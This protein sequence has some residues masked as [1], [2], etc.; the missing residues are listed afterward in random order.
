MS[1]ARKV[2]EKVLDA[3]ARK[4]YKFHASQCGFRGFRS[5]ETA[6]LRVT[7][8][9]TN[10]CRYLAVLDL[11]QA[12]A[13]VPRGD[14]IEQIRTKL[15]ANTANM[16][17]AML[18]RTLVST[19]GDSDGIVREMER[20][21]P[22]GSPLSP[23]LFNFFI[24]PLAGR[25]EAWVDGDFEN[26]VNL[27]ADDIIL[28][29]PTASKMQG[30]LSICEDFASR[31]GLEWGVTKCHA[32]RA[33]EAPATPLYL[34]GNELK[35]CASAEYLGVEVDASGV[36]DAATLERICRAGARIQM[37]KASVIARPRLT[38]A[39]LQQVYGALIRPV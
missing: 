25:I 26:A 12:Y 22:E 10:G 28:L 21:V 9:I 36:T 13:S 37:L 8:A 6:I 16:I 2:L 1:H 17:E 30:L 5:V 39:R 23:W 34:D 14:L 31:N 35:Y 18:W 7:R 38:S 33:E 3:R 27:F 4:Q 29:A 32:L 15:D 19:V 20:G 24:N 11:R